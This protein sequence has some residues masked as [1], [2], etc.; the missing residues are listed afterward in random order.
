MK[1][2]LMILLATLCATVAF[3]QGKYKTT[4]TIILYN[5]PN[6]AF[7]IQTYIYPVS[8]LDIGTKTGEFWQVT[9]KEKVRYMPEM[10]LKDCIPADSV[11]VQKPKVNLNTIIES[12]DRIPLPFVRFDNSNKISSEL[13]IITAGDELYSAGKLLLTST[14]V[15]IGGGALSYVLL[16]NDSY[17]LLRDN[18]YH[19]AGIICGIGTGIATLALQI[20]GY[21]KLM[22]AGEKFYIGA[23]SAGIGMTINLNE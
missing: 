22:K 11:I 21:R 20:A 19:L 7:G 1:K 16:Q 8:F 12:V 5:K 9:Y 2:T 13:E 6:L 3:G 4:N 18:P 14:F 17:V 23:T 10:F 15:G